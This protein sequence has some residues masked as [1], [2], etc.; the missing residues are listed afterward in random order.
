[1]IWTAKVIISSF[2]L[3]S[4]YGNFLTKKDRV[5]NE[6]NRHISYEPTQGNVCGY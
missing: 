2:H 3:L 4:K 1:M 5:A 6:K